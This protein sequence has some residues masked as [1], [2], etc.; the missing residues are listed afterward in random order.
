MAPTSLDSA[1]M[2]AT[3][4][5]P[6]GLLSRIRIR[7]MTIDPIWQSNISSGRVT[8]SS[9]PAEFATENMRWRQQRLEWEEAWYLRRRHLRAEGSNPLDLPSSAP[10]ESRNPQL[11]L[12]K[13]HE[14]SWGPSDLP[15]WFW[16]AE[17]CPPSE[18]PNEA[19]RYQFG[20]QGVDPKGS[21]EMGTY[22]RSEDVWNW[23]IDELCHRPGDER[24]DWVPGLHA[25]GG[26]PAKF[27]KENRECDA[28]EH[29]WEEEW[30]RR[31]RR[32]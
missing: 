4:N 8:F 14:E 9:R 16:D 17:R 10:A 29:A 12:R 20:E 27:E 2:S 26:R 1:M 5:M 31:A 3:D 25:A 13:Y 22:I 21:G 28:A 15:D 32:R 19:C 11:L 30:R 23:S 24:F 7:L 18:P 6:C